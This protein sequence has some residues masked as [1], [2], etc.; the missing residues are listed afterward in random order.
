VLRSAESRAIAL[1]FM[2]SGILTGTLSSRWP[3]IAGRLHMGSAMIGAVGLASTV[4]ALLTMPFAARFLHRYGAGAATCALTVASG[5]TLALPPFAPGVVVL[6]IMLLLM[7]AA[8]GCQ[9][10][11]IN[12]AGVEAETRLGRSIMSG[13]HGM[14]SVGVLVGALI[15]SLAARTGLDPRVQFIAMAAVIVVSGLVS[16]AFVPGGA[17]S[18][19]G[20]DDAAPVHVPIFVWPRG[21]VLL[22]GLVAFA[23]IFVEFA[24]ASWAALF[25][26]WSLHSSQAAAAFATAMFALA[27]AAGRL[28]GDAVVERI[29]AVRSVRACGVLAT[30]GCLVVAVAPGAW[31]AIAGFML[32]GVGV[33]VVVPVVFAAAGH[34]GPSPAIGVAGVATISYGAGLAAP[35]IMGGVADLAS[36]RAAF[37]VS[38]LIAV[39][40]GVGAGLLARPARQEPVPGPALRRGPA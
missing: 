39:M 33:S 15:G 35:S 21:V 36:L 38:A 24:A 6:A 25:M 31:L 34:S 28:C 11:A 10:N 16:L 32:I 17:A 40:I 30:A 9:D 5:I 27:M 22:I 18:G 37:A 8:V 20:A 12:T 29:G 19:P 4:G 14:W 13:L 7:G 23:A 3:W 1:V 26:H 2:T